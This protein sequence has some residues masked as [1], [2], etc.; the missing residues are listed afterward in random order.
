MVALCIVLVRSSLVAGQEAAP[1]RAPDS[2]GIAEATGAECRQRPMFLLAVRTICV[3]PPLVGGVHVPG[4]TG[5]A[6]SW[7][8]KFQ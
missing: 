6:L 5:V 1:S 4:G 2:D 8:L 3:L 7:G